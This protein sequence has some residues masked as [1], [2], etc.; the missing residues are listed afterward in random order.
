MNKFILFV[1]IKI[2][3]RWHINT[4]MPLRVILSSRF[5]KEQRIEWQERA[6]M[7]K[8]EP[9]YVRIVTMIGEKMWMK[10]AS[11]PILTLGHTNV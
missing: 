4:H 11:E 10:K 2:V 8:G 3:I 7:M 1:Q 5:E 9:M 6:K